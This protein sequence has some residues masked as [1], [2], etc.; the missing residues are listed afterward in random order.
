MNINDLVLFGEESVKKNFDW[1]FETHGLKVY[2]VDDWK[3][4][5]PEYRLGLFSIRFMTAHVVDFP[6]L[7]PFV[8]FHE[9][10]GHRLFCEKTKAGKK[11]R[12]LEN[13]IW[14]REKKLFPEEYDKIS[15]VKSTDSKI[16]YEN[17]ELLVFFSENDSEIR[18]FYDLLEFSSNLF[19]KNFVLYESFANNIANVLLK[20]FSEEFRLS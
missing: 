20:E 13:E 7:S 15:F 11:L 9:Y 1:V 19:K 2:S 12:D 5:M 17:N 4:I 14:T 8:F 16:I 18:E 10:C 6:Y 3:K